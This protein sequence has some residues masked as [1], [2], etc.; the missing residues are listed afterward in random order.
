MLIDLNAVPPA[1]IEGVEAT[2]ENIRRKTYKVVRPF[3]FVFKSEPQ[4][5]AK[6]FLEFV[7]SESG[8][9]ILVQEGLVSVSALTP[10]KDGE[11][12]P[13]GNV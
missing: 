8:Q 2:I 10:A 9:R 3:L 5:A 11:G 6:K 7:L 1:G 13:E 4:D 12:K